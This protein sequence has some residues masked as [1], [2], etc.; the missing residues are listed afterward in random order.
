[1]SVFKVRFVRSFTLTV[2]A[3]SR[4]ALEDALRAIGSDEVEDMS[5]SV[6][7]DPAEVWD[8]NEWDTSRPQSVLVNGKLVHPDYAVKR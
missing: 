2:A 5:G 8:R 3:E 4:Q 6:D 1:M 7:W